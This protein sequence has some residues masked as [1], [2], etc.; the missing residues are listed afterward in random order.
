MSISGGDVCMVFLFYLQ[1][2]MDIEEITR[3]FLWQGGNAFAALN[4][5]FWELFKHWK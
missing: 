3:S 2:K 5:K 4:N 1:V